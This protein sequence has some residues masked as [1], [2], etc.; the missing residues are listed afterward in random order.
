MQ[1][2][3]TGFIFSR[4]LLEKSDGKTLEK[5]KDYTGTVTKS[6][7]ICPKGTE[8]NTV[9]KAKKAFTAKWSKQS[10]KMSRKTS[11]RISGLKVRKTYYVQVR[12]YMKVDGGAY[13]SP[14]SKAGSVKIRCLNMFLF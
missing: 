4:S 9:K 14:W 8:I 3:E 11:V 2:A 1:F 13:Y 5:N 6:F 7:K 10:A 12:T